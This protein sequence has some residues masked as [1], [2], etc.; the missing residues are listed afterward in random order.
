MVGCAVGDALGASFEGRFRRLPVEEYPFK[1]R[2]TDDT[3]MMLGIAESLIMKEGLDEEHMMD[4]FIENWEREPWRGYGPGPPN[5]FSMVKKGI[6]WKRAPQRLYSGEGSFGN[7]SAMRVAPIGLLFPDQNLREMAYRSSSLTHTHPLGK[8]GAAV[9]AFSV[10]L[11]SNSE[12]LDSEDFLCEVRTFAEEEAYENKIRS[13]IELLDEENSRAVVD[14]LGNTVEA[15]NSVPTAIYCFAR[16]VNDFRKALLYA[17]GLGG[18]TDTIGAM[19][20]AIAGAYHG[21][22][23]IPREWKD[24]LEKRDYIK[25]LAQDLWKLKRSL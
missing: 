8:E 9:Q 4:T 23:A 7:G 18:D 10:A 24:K 19:T 11:A 15:F 1:G 22:E 17:V 2:W 13:A 3:H 5:V 16:N 14:K 21:A 6:S 25:S 20:G 12:R